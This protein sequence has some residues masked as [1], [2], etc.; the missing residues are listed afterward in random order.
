MDV[1]RYRRTSRAAADG[2]Q[3]AGREGRRR[4]R[5]REHP[6][7]RRAGALASRRLVPSKASQR[8]AGRGHRIGKTHLASAIAASVIRARVRSRYFNTVDLVTQLEEETRIGKAGALA[9]QLRRHEL[10][11]LDELGY[12]PSARSVASCCSTLSASST[13]T[14]L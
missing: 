7:Q 10:V 5:V 14:P 6:D 8:R 11:V 4:V 9:A 12:L 2:R 1:E 3:T 13:S